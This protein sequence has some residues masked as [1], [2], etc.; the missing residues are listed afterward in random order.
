MMT[1][2]M[3]LYAGNSVIIKPSEKSALVGIKIGEL[4]TGSRLSGGH[5]S[6][7]VTG[8]M[9]KPARLL[10]QSRLGRLIF[11]GSVGCGQ[12]VMAQASQSTDAC[13]PSSSAAKTRLLFCPMLPSIGRPADSSGAHLQMP[14]RPALRS[15]ECTLSKASKQK[16]SSSASPPVRAV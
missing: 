9:P 13:L 8:D 4:F 3:A 2:I 7:L 11:T 14:A 6:R 5:A 10:S 12:A 1:A 15:S 16:K